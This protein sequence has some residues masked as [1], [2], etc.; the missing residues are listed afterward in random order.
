M[1]SLKYINFYNFFSPYTNVRS[2]DGSLMRMGLTKTFLFNIII[3]IFLLMLVWILFKIFDRKYLHMKR[4]N[5]ADNPKLL[6]LFMRYKYLSYIFSNYIFTFT[7]SSF[8]LVVFSY[9][10][11]TQS[12]Q[13]L[14]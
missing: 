8:I 7:I 4:L 13:E 5:V 14:T 6:A 12:N 1:N 3:Q 10:S 9:L 2:L 11:I